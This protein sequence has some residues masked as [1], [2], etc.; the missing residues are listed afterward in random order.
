MIYACLVF[1][2]SMLCLMDLWKK[3]RL[4]RFIFW[5]VLVGLCIFMVFVAGLRL[6]VGFD[7]YTYVNMFRNTPKLFTGVFSHSR[8]AHGEIGFHFL[9]GL[10]KFLGLTSASSLFTIFAIMAILLNVMSLRRYTRFVGHAFFLYLCFYFFGREMG[11]IRQGLATAVLF[12]SVQYVLNR[13]YRR[14][15]AFVILAST[16]HLSSFVF[17][18]LYWVGNVRFRKSAYWSLLVLGVVLALFPWHIYVFPLLP[19]NLPGI[20]YVGS[21]YGQAV[22]LFSIT[23]LRRLLPAVLVLVT[24]SRV[25][26][27]AGAEFIVF[28]NMVVMGS[29]LSLMFR[30]VAIFAERLVVP[31]LFAEIVVYPF[32]LNYFGSKAWRVIWS[33]FIVLL[34]VIFVYNL[35]LNNSHLYFPYRSVIS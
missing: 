19:V 30:H 11:Q 13:D 9:S 22:G 29:F 5:Y 7:Y 20:G 26:D 10:L 23:M 32:F 15:V 21:R 3:N 6:D 31:Y 17:L 16:I 12:F 4:N 34:G 1:L 14:F 28:H 33:I 8:E 27:R 18:P 24:P 2:G 25:Q 35:F